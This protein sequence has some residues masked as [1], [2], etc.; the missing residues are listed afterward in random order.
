M[1]KMYEEWPAI[2]ETAGDRGSPTDQSCGARQR[3]IAESQQTGQGIDVPE[4]NTVV[5]YF[6]SSGDEIA[7]LNLIGHAS[8]EISR[9]PFRHWLRRYE[10]DQAGRWSS[11]HIPHK[12]M[13]PKQDVVEWL[14]AVQEAAGH[15]RR[16]SSPI[17]SYTLMRQADMS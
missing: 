4:S 9:W 3:A 2:C 10:G 7:E 17:D 5:V 8:L 6:S 15:S 1:I 14:Y 12:R 11:D 13:K 16:P